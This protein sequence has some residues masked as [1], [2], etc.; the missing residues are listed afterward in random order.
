ML[1]SVGH[2]LHRTAKLLL[3]WGPS[4]ATL[5]LDIAHFHLYQ[6]AQMKSRPSVRRAAGVCGD[7]GRFDSTVL[8]ASQFAAFC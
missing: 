1:R 8:T 5:V 2:A 4:H 7:P 3:D 6:E